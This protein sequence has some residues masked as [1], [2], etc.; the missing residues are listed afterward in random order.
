MSEK[1]PSDLVAATQLLD[2]ELDRV[3][4]LAD[5]A[6]RVPLNSRKNLE[7]AARTTTEAAE[8]QGKVGEHISALMAA[9]NQVRVRNEATVQ[10]LQTRSDEIQKRSEQLG[11]LLERFEAI[12]KDAREVTDLAQGIGTE[13]AGEKLLELET[14]L[15]AIAEAAK[16][17]WEQA[18]SDGWTDLSRDADS[19]RQQV[20]AAK[21]KLGLLAKRMIG[22]N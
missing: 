16:G 8:S 17:L 18:E 10:A 6:G 12:G 1:K 5:S 20:L 9:L 7:K 21:N 11:A 19:L 3:E 2:E 15:G 13:G 14:R 22:P 4:H